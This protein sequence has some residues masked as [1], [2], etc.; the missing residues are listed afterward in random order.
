MSEQKKT[1]T[2]GDSRK[3]A[4]EMCAKSSGVI[5]RTVAFDNDDVPRFLENLRRFEEHSREVR[6]VVK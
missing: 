5:S 6:I 1:M 2:A 4:S 3:L